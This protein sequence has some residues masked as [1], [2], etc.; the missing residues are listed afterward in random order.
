MQV[1]LALLNNPYSVASNTKSSNQIGFNGN[2]SLNIPTILKDGVYSKEAKDTFKV[3]KKQIEK[4]ASLNDL[5]IHFALSGDPNDKVCLFTT[6]REHKSLLGSIPELISK[7]SG[8][9]TVPFNKDPD[10]FI[11]S[12]AEA[13]DRFYNPNLY[14]YKKV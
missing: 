9:V 13:I 6:V 2:V 5:D 10:T 3:V 12:S 11:K 8:N 1:N 14:T 7:I 4:T